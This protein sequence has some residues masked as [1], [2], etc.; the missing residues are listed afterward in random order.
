MQ[1]QTKLPVLLLIIIIPL[2][3]MSRANAQ[4]CDQAFLSARD[5]YYNGQFENI[6]NLLNPCITEINNNRD[7]FTQNN[8][9]MIFKVYK[10]LITSY[11]D[12]DYD[13]LGEEKKQQLIN[14]FSG[15]Y[16]PDDVLYYLNNTA[17]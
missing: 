9:G 4:I 5:Q 1:I 6:Q 11:Y 13:Y 16:S 10:L 14:F 17:F 15:I 12:S 2:L 3:F 8:Q 7:Y